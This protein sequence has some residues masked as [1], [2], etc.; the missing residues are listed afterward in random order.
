MKNIFSLSCTVLLALSTSTLTFGQDAKKGEPEGK[1]V[2]QFKADNT[3]L[4]PEIGALVTEERGTIVVRMVP[5]VAQL[6]Q[7][8]QAV[9]LVVGDEVAMANGKRIK[10]VKELKEALAQVAVGSECKIGV[11]REGTARLITFTKRDPKDL[12]QGRRMIIRQD[13]PGADPNSDTFPAFGI[14]IAKQGKD[15]V[16]S[17]TMPHAPKNIKKGDVVKS[18]NGKPIASIADFNEAFDA[19]KIGSPITLELM[20]DGTAVTVTAPRPEPKGQMII[21]N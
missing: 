10:T 17:E 12:P 14:G 2:M 11:R 20:R 6:S 15:V 13:G 18:L 7:G 4:I 16:I 5:P 8:L 21:K 1:R 9:D 19:T 3:V